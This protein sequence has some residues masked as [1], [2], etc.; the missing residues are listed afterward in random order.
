MGQLSL[1]CTGHLRDNRQS[2][3]LCSSSSSKTS[4]LAKYTLP[5]LEKRFFVLAGGEG[6]GGGGG[7]G[8]SLAR[9]S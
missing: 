9:E 7:E 6:G 3:R 1:A 4:R 8:G 2:K 5:V